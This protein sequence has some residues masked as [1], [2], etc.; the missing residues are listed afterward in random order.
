MSLFGA[1]ITGV[2]ALSAQAQSISMIA[3]NIANVTTVGYKRREAS[4]ESLVTSSSSGSNYTPGSVLARALQKIDG[5]GALEQTSSDTDVA[6][7]GNGTF[8]VQRGP[9]GLQ[10]ALFTRAGAFTED[11]NGFLRNTA[12]FYLMGWRLDNAGNLPAG[13][14]DISSLEAVNVSLLGGLTKAT[15]TATFNLNLNA[16]EPKNVYPIVAGSTPDFSRT[17]KV[18]DSLGEGQ[19]LQLTFTHHDSPTVITTSNYTATP[20][21]RSTILATPGTVP[22]PGLP[23]I[24]VGETLRVNI[25][26]VASTYTITSTS[27]VQDFIDFVNNDPSLKAVGNA[28]FTDTGQIR[29]VAKD[30][31]NVALVTSGTQVGSASAAATLGFTTMAPYAHT[32]GAAGT[33]LSSTTV[34]NTIAGVSNTNQIAV[35]VNGTTST[36]TVAAGLTVQDFI[37][38]VNTGLAGLARAELTSDGRIRVQSLDINNAVTFANASGTP[39]T[40]L[41]MTAVAE[42]AP[43]PP[44]IIPD[45]DLATD[46]NPF[47]WWELNIID[48]DTGTLIK[49]GSLNFGSDGVLNGQTDLNGLKSI[50]LNNINWGNGSDLQNIT[51]DI[52]SITQF[53]GSYNVTSASQDGAELGLRTGVDIDRNGVVSARFSNGETSALFKLPLATFTSTNSLSEQTGNAFIQTSESGSYNLR[54]AGAGGAGLVEGSALEAS[55]VDIADEF[56]K[57]IVTQRAYSAGTKIIQTADQMTEELLRLR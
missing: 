43:T 44:T 16:A 23:G 26:T 55:N 18:F 13:R 8:V 46:A 39:A 2:S 45:N 4:F 49:Q 14:D 33:G 52:S 17:T 54:E 29:I 42:T 12:G 9:T 40:A 20:L 10:E 57:M 28:E 6:I 21:L 51:I 37:D 50:A 5:Q 11:A 7:S 47:G 32:T 34:M 22:N 56:T 24:E 15:S 1:L 38:A 19:N 31:N 27:T 53:S 3:N 30:F 48:A 41:G 35:T 36:F 25:G